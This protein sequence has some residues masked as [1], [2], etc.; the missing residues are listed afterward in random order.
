[1]KK[2][3]IIVLLLLVVMISSIALSGCTLVKL[4]EERQASR[5]MAT[6]SYDVNVTN[7]EAKDMLAQIGITDYTVSNEIDRREL[8]SSTNYSINRM[9]SLYAQYSMTYNYD[10]ETVMGD[11]LDSLISNNYYVLR[12][13]EYLLN[14]SSTERLK[15]MYMFCRPEDY[16]AV[17][18][19]KLSAEGVLTMAEWYSAVGTV[20][21]T[22]Q[23]MLDGYIEDEEGDLR[24]D[25]ISAADN[26]ISEYYEQGYFVSNVY[27]VK[28][29]DRAEGET[30]GTAFKNV[31]E[32]NNKKDVV[33]YGED[34]EKYVS[35]LYV[36]D[37]GIVLTGK[38][39]SDDSASDAPA[40]SELDYKKVYAAI[41]LTKKEGGDV[42][43]VPRPASEASLTVARVTD[44][45][46]A[47]KYIRTRSVTVSYTG[48]VFAEKTEDN[49]TGY[50]SQS[51]ISDTVEY[52]VA[53]PRNAL[54][55][56]AEEKDYL[57]EES[58]R[59]ATK[60]TWNEF[61]AY[62]AVEGN[63]D[64]E[65]KELITENNAA[66]DALTAEKKELYVGLASLYTAPFVSSYSGSDKNVKDGYRQ[67]RNTLSSA[68]IGFVAEE[69]S[70]KSS[71]EYAYFKCYNGMY[72]YYNEQFMSKTL[73]AVQF[74]I[75]LAVKSQVKVSDAEVLQSYVAKVSQDKA[76]YDSLGYTEQINKFFSN[77]TSISEVYYVPMEALQNERYEVDP[78]SKSYS[79]LFSFNP[80]GSVS[81]YDHT[82]VNYDTTDGKYYMNYVYDNGDGTY[83]I[84][85]FFVG[86]LL[87]GFGNDEDINNAVKIDSGKLVSIDGYKDLSYEKKLQLLNELIDQLKTGAQITEEGA[88]QEDVTE[89]AQL[90][91]TESKFVR[92]II[93]E[94]EDETEGKD[95]DEIIEI[96]EK[97]MAMYNDDS[98]KLSDPGYLITSGDV[99]DSW[100]MADFPDGARAI[101][102]NLLANGIDPNAAV[103]DVFGEGMT[104]YGLHFMMVTLAPY[105]RIN[106]LK[107]NID[108]E[109]CFA[110]PMNTKLNLA[111]D[112][113]GKTIRESLEDAK[114]S[115]DYSAW[116][117][118]FAEDTIN[119]STVR[120]DKNY[121]QLVKD[122][123]KENK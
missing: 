67:L 105:Y 72:E 97:Y 81:D 114:S 26:K 69:P 113:Q 60:D 92:D 46:F 111:G 102:Y 15:S 42:V 112:M 104:Y 117:A 75:G 50:T 95:R 11:T 123:K 115:S 18:G 85:A 25:R 121:K 27:L 8:L 83:T 103:E 88:L 98:G 7:Q 71:I 33:V 22:L 36:G 80:D 62:I 70:D 53:F 87:F 12:A 93:T 57:K 34:G 21:E 86:A 6:V 13:I 51:F 54:A 119:A 68:G 82:Y 78:E 45:D 10:Y 23:T 52:Q 73:D 37:K 84:N 79:A 64:S 24:N 122:I 3:G 9:A 32:S 108:G 44:A 28:N 43:Y 41:E 61:Y 77:T 38:V 1:M 90:F 4:N 17:Y 58:V 101:Y 110:L 35:G 89:I 94:I 5:V 91:D 40:A 55:E 16:K 74:E 59:Y 30:A 66:Y 109:E 19:N 100:A 48:R 99:K 120:N 76:K 106:L 29:V 96:F 39:D 49:D 107:V 14:N 63:Y 65:K 20:N 2:K 31:S 47:G 116:Q 118:S 56:K